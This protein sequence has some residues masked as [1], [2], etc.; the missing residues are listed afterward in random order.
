MLNTC[1]K[2]VSKNHERYVQ[3][4]FKIL[5]C[6][7]MAMACDDESPLVGQYNP[8]DVTGVRLFDKHVKADQLWP[9]SLDKVRCVCGTFDEDGNNYNLLS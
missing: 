5:D 9:G 8:D 3:R 7:P 4:L 2:H 6:Q 1:A